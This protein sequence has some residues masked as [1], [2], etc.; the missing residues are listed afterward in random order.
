[1][2]SR[3]GN[4]MAIDDLVSGAKERVLE[5]SEAQYESLKQFSDKQKD[6]IALKIAIGSIKY[7]LLRLEH[8]QDLHFDFEDI[9]DTKTNGSPYIQYTYARTYSI[10][11]KSKTQIKRIEENKVKETNEDEEGLLREL[12]HFNEIVKLASNNFSPHLLTTY[13]FDL[14]KAYNA[15]Y[16]KHKVLSND[17]NEYIRLAI[18]KT[19]SNIIKLSMEILGIEVMNKL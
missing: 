14:C 15:F 5:L 7:A 1:M 4:V 2:S 17:D 13:L 16:E 6:E 19:I 9:L 12:L 8:N 10:L 18:T 3:I 11:E